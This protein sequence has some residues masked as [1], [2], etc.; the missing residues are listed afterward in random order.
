MRVFM[1]G[2]CNGSTWRAFLEGALHD[3]SDINLFNP[4][5]EDWT[6]ACVEAE[7]KVKADPETVNLFV[8]TAQMT[9][10]YSIAEVVDS[11]HLKP[12]KTIFLVL[13]DGF[14]DGQIRS[15][16]AVKEL[17]HNRGGYVA[18]SLSGLAYYL[19]ELID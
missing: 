7:N 13:E 18:S 9:G 2:T 16:N 11:V 12:K 14:N 19:Q 8:V 6:P 17:I 3:V 1:G 4:V 15:L 5:V 10:V